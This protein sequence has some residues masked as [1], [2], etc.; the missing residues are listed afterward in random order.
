MIDIAAMRLRAE[1]Y[2]ADAYDMS[3][4]RD[5]IVM[6]DAIT[7]IFALADEVVRL[8]RIIDGYDR[9]DLE[10][11]VHRLQVENEQLRNPQ[12]ASKPAYLSDPTFV[13]IQG[14]W[15]EGQCP[16]CKMFDWDGIDLKS[17]SY[18]GCSCCGFCY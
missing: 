12:W 7:D 14:P 11:E 6:R 1:G 9:T 16:I 3:A 4:D 13:P 18:S 5:Y 8:Q 17:K 2:I 15:P 10:A